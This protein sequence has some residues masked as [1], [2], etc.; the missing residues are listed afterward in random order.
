MEVEIMN[1]RI[2][3]STAVAFVLRLSVSGAVV[4]QIHQGSGYASTATPSSAQA[5]EGP[6]AKIDDE[7]GKLTIAHGPLKGLAMPSM[8]M[9]FG[10]AERTILENVKVGDKIRFVPA[11]AGGELTVIRLEVIR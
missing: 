11:Q 6:V 1:D 2:L 8:T 5:A 7:A 10:V 4:A 3:L 9:A